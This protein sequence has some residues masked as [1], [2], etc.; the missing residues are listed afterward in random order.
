MKQ[1]AFTIMTPI[2][3]TQ[4]GELDALLDEIGDDV[5]DN[6]HLRFDQL[7]NLHYASFVTVAVDGTD[8]YL[9]FEGNVD[10]PSGAFLDQLV[11]KA[12]DAIDTIYRHC[13]DYPEAGTLDRDAVLAYLKAHDIGANA[14]YV[15]W[16]GRTVGEIR[17]EQ[18]LR[19]HIE[20]FVDA[21]EVSL[22]EQPADVVRQRIQGDISDDK[23]MRWAVT[24]AS[25]PFLVKNGTNVVRLL[26]VPA[27][28]TFLMLG[29]AALGRS[30]RRAGM[31]SRLVLLGMAALVGYLARR[32]RSEEAADDRENRTRPDWESTYASSRQ[33]LASIARREDFLSQNHLAS[34][35]RIKEGWFRL[36]TLRVVLWAIN[37]VA[38]VS[39]NKGSLGGISSIHF[40]RWVI[41]PGG[42]HLVFL[43][44]FDGSWQSYLSDFID[45]AARGLTAVWTNTDNEIGF[46]RT[47][48]LLLDGARDE[49][50]FKA[51][52]RYSQLRTRVWYCAYPDLSMANIG[53]NMRL[54]DQLCEP[55]DTEG[56]EAWLRRL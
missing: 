52:A 50:R 2:D 16:P 51:Y 49:A 38:R 44:N 17:R 1:S 18:Q 37:L 30:G 9:L 48:W 13:V 46:P 12:G 22:R 35:T 26:A 3:R 21:H 24:P 6:P 31:V 32:L 45:L 54:R 39:A 25:Q 56:A 28:V 47:R 41:A 8:P 4:V 42:K 27:G 14:F 40:A 33:R 29:K 20:A 7:D 19:E 15:G 55:L 36:L 11:D 5:D 53:N 23:S 34:V 43:S 10:G